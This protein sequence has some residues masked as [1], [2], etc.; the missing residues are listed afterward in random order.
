MIDAPYD[1]QVRITW[2]PRKNE[3]NRRERGLSFERVADFDFE[4]AL[5]VQDLRQNYG[6]VRYRALGWIEEELH[7]LVFTFREDS[8]RVISLRRASRK[9]RRDYVEKTGSGD[10]GRR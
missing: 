7:A 9:E 4:T 5:I 6:E 10:G 8:I 2:D 3:R 1:F